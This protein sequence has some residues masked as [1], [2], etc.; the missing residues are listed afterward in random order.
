MP[1]KIAWTD[2]AWNPVTGCT[3]I[4]AGCQN[5][6]AERMAK[7]LK[8]MGQPKYR[9]GFD[10]TFHPD[11]L[12]EPLKWKRPRRVFVCSMGDL[13]H[14][15]VPFEF[16]AAAFA[17]MGLAGD[18]TFQVLTKRPERMVEFFKWQEDKKLSS[19][20]ADYVLQPHGWSWGAACSNL[21]G[22]CSRQRP[23][24]NVW[25]GTSVST[26]GDTER[27]A[28]LL[29]SSASIQ[30]VSM[31]PLLEAVYLGDFTIYLDWVIVGC[32]SGPGARPCNLDWVRSIRDQC[33][34]AGVPLFVKQL[35]LGGRV[36]KDV[37]QFPEDLQIQEF[38]R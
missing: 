30:F 19:Y 5:C 8:A 7:R 33:R 11:S 23:L 36:V 38:P 3:K 14:D 22:P 26:Q 34:A 12:A 27:I 2:E 37:E 17:V 16:I 1:T 4:A 21:D 10:V 20:L 18:Q 15:D 28:E 25:L 31:E 13:F 9:N 32:E 29:D 24:S 6:Y 35:E